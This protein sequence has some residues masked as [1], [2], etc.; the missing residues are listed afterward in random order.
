[1]RMRRWPSGVVLKQTRLQYYVSMIEARQF[2]AS[3]SKMATKEST[4]R[5]SM[6]SKQD[7]VKEMTAREEKRRVFPGTKVVRRS[8]KA[9]AEK[10]RLLQVFSELPPELALERLKDAV[11]CSDKVLNALSLV[12]DKETFPS[13]SLLT[14]TRCESEFDPNYNTLTSC[15]LPHPEI[16]RIHKSSCGSVWKC[17]ECGEEWQSSDYDTFD[18]VDVGD[19]FTGPHTTVVESDSDPDEE[20]ALKRQ[21]YW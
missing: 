9:L 14:C 2:R 7:E 13:Q 21:R 1:M 3:A 4:K 17:D 5:P 20:Y 12:F 8:K 10:E 6:K 16:D 18:D 15:T 11:E 19:C